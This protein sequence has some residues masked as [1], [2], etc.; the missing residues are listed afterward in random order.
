MEGRA[1]M[2][3][4]NYEIRMLRNVAGEIKKGLSN[5]ELIK[6]GRGESFRNNDTLDKLYNNF[7][8]SY[9]KQRYK[10]LIEMGW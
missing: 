6:D 5:L 8:N 10:E 3:Y 1:S 9:W 2:K 4:E 7:R